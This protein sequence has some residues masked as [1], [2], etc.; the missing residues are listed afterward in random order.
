MHFIRV[1]F[2]FEFPFLLTIYVSLVLL[3]L[4]KYLICFCN[5][6]CSPLSE[7][8][9]TVG[10]GL[11]VPAA[12]SGRMPMADVFKLAVSTFKVN[13]WTLFGSSAW[14]LLRRVMPRRIKK[15]REKL[16]QCSW[17]NWWHF[18]SLSV[19]FFS[20][21]LVLSWPLFKFLPQIWFFNLIELIFVCSV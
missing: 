20:F 16:P 6:G 9:T 4:N 14:K 17:F 13:D 3:N 11:A 8:A 12:Q 21:Y 2:G 1:K 15:K 19:S 5:C 10:A 18:N 7:S